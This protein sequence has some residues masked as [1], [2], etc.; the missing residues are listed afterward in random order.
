MHDSLSLRCANCDTPLDPPGLGAL[1][2]T[3]PVCQ[4]FNT[5]GD[6]PSSSTIS[7]DAFGTQLSD[8]V[9]YA[10]ASEI[11]LDII[12]STLRD[13]LEFTAELASGG[14]DLFVQIIDL[15]PRVGEPLRQSSREA[16]VMLRGRTAGG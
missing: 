12:V 1:G 10:R 3:C 15:G 4:L 9:A 8:L 16:N 13:E 7:P 11:P 14:R 6:A 2:V 5:L